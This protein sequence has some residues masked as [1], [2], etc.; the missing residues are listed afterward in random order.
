ME[1]AAIDEAVR[2]FVQARRSGEPIAELPARCK[3]TSAAEV[4]AIVDAV[5]AEL[6]ARDGEKIAGWKIGF[7]YSPRQRPM[8]CPLFESRLFDSPARVPL[9]VTSGLR[10]EP[11]ISFRLTTDL[12]PRAKP[13]RPAEVAEALDACAS[14]E[15]IDT[16]FDTSRRTLRQMIDDKSS[17][18]EAMADHNTT[19]AYITAPG[20]GDWQEFDF[21]SLRVTMRTPSRTLVETVG[22]H[23]FVDPFLPC[24]VLVNEMRH[25]G[26]VRAGEL[27]VTGS[28]SGFFPVDVGE[29]VTAE[30]E[31][32]GCVE[33]VYTSD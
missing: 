7:L 27:L 32:F 8:I 11:E 24:V 31:G 14:L 21:A 23:A 9:S 3:P 13:Y 10:I 12:P 2:L 16:R 17:R 5:T 33:A 4:N 15:M 26:G 6:V 29:P 30:F 22:G 20:R 1:A 25:R 28:F 18:L 19:G